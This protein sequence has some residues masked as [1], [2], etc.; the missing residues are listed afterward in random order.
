MVAAVTR[1]I[2]HGINTKELKK[3]VGEIPDTMRKGGSLKLLFI[4]HTDIVNE[5]KIQRYKTSAKSKL[6]NTIKFLQKNV[7][8]FK[9]TIPRQSVKHKVR[10]NTANIQLPHIH[11]RAG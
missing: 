6:V 4:V 9:T 11:E 10:Y 3:R 2:H 7:R 8:Q 1:D 5:F